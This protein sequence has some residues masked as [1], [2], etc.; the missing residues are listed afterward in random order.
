MGR[1]RLMQFVNNISTGRRLYL[2]YKE[3][4]YYSNNEYS[5]RLAKI[6]NV[7]YEDWNKEVEENQINSN[8]AA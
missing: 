2:P 3:L 4:T 8:I 7:T 5:N 1:E 6:V